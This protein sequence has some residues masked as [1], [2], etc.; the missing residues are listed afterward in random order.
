MAE[1][2]TLR[3]RKAESTS[4]RV[5]ASP[6]EEKDLAPSGDD[7]DDLSSAADKL[8]AKPQ[9]LLVNQPA[10]SRWRNWCIRGLVTWLM[11]FAFA[12]IIY[13]GHVAL[14]IMIFALQLK[15][16]HEIISIAH[17]RYKENQLP[18]FRSLN[19]YFV[20]V[21]NFYFFGEGFG[22]YFQSF[23]AGEES[24]PSI[25][26]YQRFI[27]FCLYM[28]GFV[29]FVLSLKRRFYKFQFTQFGWTH[30]AI[31]LVVSQSHLVIQNMFF[32]LAWLL[33]PASLVVCNDIMA[34]MFGFFFGRTPLIKL[35]PKKTWEGFIGAF[36]ST[37]V[38]SILFSLFLSEHSYFI[39]PVERLTWFDEK[40]LTCT[41]NACFQWT[42][43]AVPGELR[44]YL[45]FLP[46]LLYY[47]PFTLHALFMAVFAS[48]IAPFG[49]FFAS[50]LKRAFLIKDFDNLIPGHGGVTDRFDC[51][52]L[53]ASFTYVFYSAFIRVQDVNRLFHI[54]ASLPVTDQ[55]ELLDRLSASLAAQ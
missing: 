30:L 15:S 38:F 55:R 33:M 31:I 49:G 52:F 47:R 25:I 32:G 41:P 39:C 16:F 29:T 34:Y 20:F 22:H 7:S 21:A 40:A 50:G 51:Q 35:S 11:L 42:A 13:L 8:D 6:K 53:M 5:A 14:T 44:A 48:L 2:T 54:I 28:L 43:L 26:R 3:Q 10:A 19:W 1:N 17:V 24:T 27:A 46:E 23:I 36:F 4:D 9:Q 18:W 12:G 45:S 37:V